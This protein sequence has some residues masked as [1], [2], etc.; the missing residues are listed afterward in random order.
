MGVTGKRREMALFRAAGNGFWVLR[1]N[2]AE[3][4]CNAFSLLNT[5]SIFLLWR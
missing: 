4:T 1:S 3:N 5:R 2:G